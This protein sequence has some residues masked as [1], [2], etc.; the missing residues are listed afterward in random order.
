MSTRLLPA[1]VMLL[2]AG[3]VVAP[4]PRPH[5]PVRSQVVI[6]PPPP[7]QASL[8]LVFTD[9]ERRAIRD[10]Y[11]QHTPPG[12]AKQGKTPPGLAKQGKVPPGHHRRLERNQHLERERA[13]QSLPRDLQLRLAPLP[14]GYVHIRVDD[15]IAILELQTRL[16]LDVVAPF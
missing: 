14:Q 6:T 4:G 10:Y 9:L 5:A 2:C 12:L 1:L 16:I 8:T 11:R 3:C 13:W 15:A 7:A